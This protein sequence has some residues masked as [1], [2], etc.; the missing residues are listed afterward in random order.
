MSNQD[1]R[2]YPKAEEDLEFIFL[3]SLREFGLKRN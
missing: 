2:L 1:Y 3:Y